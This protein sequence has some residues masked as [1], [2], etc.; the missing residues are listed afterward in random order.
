M[1]SK[2]VRC[3][4]Q[5]NLSLRTPNKII[6]KNNNKW[7]FTVGS[8]TRWLFL[9][10]LIPDR[11]GIWKCLWREENRRTR[12]KTLGARTRTNNKLN[13]H[14]APGR[15]RTRATLVGGERSHHCAIPAPHNTDT[16]LIFFLQT[17][18]LVQKDQNLHEL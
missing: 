13:P 14:M 9:I 2:V 1:F 5:S 6:I 17:V 15:N 3:Q 10:P 11:N 12:R 18:H 8:S 16:S 7:E 4:Q